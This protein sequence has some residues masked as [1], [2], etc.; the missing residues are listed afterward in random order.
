MSLPSAAKANMLLKHLNTLP[1]EP[2]G[3]LQTGPTQADF[4][5]VGFDNGEDY[6]EALS[7]LK[8]QGLVHVTEAKETW[9]LARS[10][11]ND[12]GQP[13]DK[14]HSLDTGYATGQSSVKGAGHDAVA[15]ALDAQRRQNDP[16]TRYG[17]VSPVSEQT[18]QAQDDAQR[19]AQDDEKKRREADLANRST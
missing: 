5:V 17:D 15:A 13:Q 14:P 11:I 3:T 19:R 10:A 16:V 2:D 1:R 7:T 18:R 9:K 12:E 8:D 4:Q 6:A